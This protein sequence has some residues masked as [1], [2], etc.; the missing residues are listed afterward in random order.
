MNANR[1]EVLLRSTKKIFESRISAGATQKLLA[2]EKPH[3]K[4]V[5]WSHD[6]EGHAKKFVERDCEQADTNAEQVYKIF[7]PCLDDQK[8]KKEIMET[9][10]EFSTSCSQIC[11]KYQFCPIWLTL[12][13]SG[14]QINLHELSQSRPERVANAWLV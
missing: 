12:T 10:G 3:A 13:S 7:T 5:A 11:V 14:L 8:F 1:T 9:V 6:M 2:W 4:T